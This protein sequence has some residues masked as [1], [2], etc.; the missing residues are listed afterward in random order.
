MYDIIEEMA[1]WNRSGEL[2]AEEF[3]CPWLRNVSEGHQCRVGCICLGLVAAEESRTRKCQKTQIKVSLRFCS[4]GV[5]NRVDDDRWKVTGF[6][7]SIPSF[8]GPS[9]NDTS[10]VRAEKPSIVQSSHLL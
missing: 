6:E 3:L 1:Q 9:Q 7:L 2:A 4:H 8:V 10:C 5:E